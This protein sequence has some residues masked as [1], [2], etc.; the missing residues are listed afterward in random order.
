MDFHEWCERRGITL[1]EFWFPPG[2]KL[3]YDTEQFGHP[4]LWV[5]HVEPENDSSLVHLAYDR[6]Y[7]DVDRERDELT[8]QPD[9]ASLSDDQP[10]PDIP[11]I[12]ASDTAPHAKNESDLRDCQ[13]IKLA[14]QQIATVI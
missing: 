8:T 10:P 12:P 6:P 13:R 7:T 14:C 5:R 4:G 2:W 3:Q 11:S 9:D 1:P